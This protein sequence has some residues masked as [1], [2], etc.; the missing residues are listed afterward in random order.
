MT[1][2]WAELLGQL[3][4]LAAVVAFSP[5][6]V[7]PAIALVV[8]S[9]RARVTGLTFIAG[10]LIGKAAVTVA[11]LGIPRLLHATLHRSA[12]SPAWTPWLQIVAGVLLLAGAL[13]YLRRPRAENP[14]TP[15]WLSRIKTI[16]PAAAGAAGVFLTVANPKIVFMCAA[17]G[18]AIG[19]AALSAPGTAG[20]V[21]YFTLLGGSTAALPILAYAIWG[22]RVD[23]QLDRFKSWLERNQVALGV[24]LMVLIGVAL[25][26][27][28]LK[29]LA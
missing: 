11:F 18:L 2:H 12:G 3:T 20:A 25:L 1:G 14:Q 4:A 22:H 19:N 28:G 10:W 13:W 26:A 16:T 8:H 29:T 15:R 17:A 6:T 5:F 7:L 21:T 24:G 9:E 23:R 27:A